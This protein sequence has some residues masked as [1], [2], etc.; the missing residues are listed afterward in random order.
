MSSF[1]RE[2]I[3]LAEHT[4]ALSDSFVGN[5]NRRFGRNFSRILGWGQTLGHTLGANH[6]TSNST[7]S[8]L[9]VLHNTHLGKVPWA[10]RSFTLS[11]WGHRSGPRLSPG[12]NCGRR[13]SALNNNS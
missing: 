4:A 1:S 5:F 11:P 6:V 10:P 13:S 7:C 9:P 2:Q 12:S 3:V 8:Q